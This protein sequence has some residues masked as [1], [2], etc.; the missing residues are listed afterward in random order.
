[1]FYLEFCFL[2]IHFLYIIHKCLIA[3]SYTSRCGIVASEIPIAWMI[4]TSCMQSTYRL[5][6]EFYWSINTIGAQ[7]LHHLRPRL[8][9]LR[10]LLHDGHNLP[11][12]DPRPGGCRHPVPR[13]AGLPGEL[14]VEPCQRQAAGHEKADPLYLR[15]LQG[16]RSRRVTMPGD[17]SQPAR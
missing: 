17:T 11:V 13:A 5:E 16:R 7:H 8:P 14:H 1:M 4:R 2:I 15:L 6:D 12:P 10:D 9:E 3:E